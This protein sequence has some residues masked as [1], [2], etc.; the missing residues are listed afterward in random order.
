[1]QLNCRRRSAMQRVDWVTTFRTD[2]WKCV[3]AVNVSTTRRRVELCRYK[4]AFTRTRSLSNATFH[5]WSRDVHPV[6]NLLLYTKFHENPMIFHR[7]MAIYRFSKWRPS[8]YTYTLNGCCCWVIGSEI[9]VFFGW[10]CLAQKYT[11][12]NMEGST[13]WDMKSM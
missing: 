3:H 8:N 12:E 11:K 1:M 6:Q 4:R 2:R 13:W 10:R 5:F 7:H 9:E